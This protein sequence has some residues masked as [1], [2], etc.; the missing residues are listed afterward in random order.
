[1][2]PLPGWTINCSHD[3][4]NY[5][6]SNTNTK[7]NN[8]ELREWDEDSE[9]ESVSS[10][11]D[12]GGFKLPRN[13]KD[14]RVD[15]FLKRRREDP[16]SS[17]GGRGASAKK[18]ARRPVSEGSARASGGGGG[19]AHRSTSS[20]EE[21]AIGSDRER[22]ADF[23]KTVES[24]IRQ[25][26][27][28]RKK[29]SKDGA[30]EAATASITAAAVSNFGR[31]PV[32][33][34]AKLQQEVGRLTAALESL[35]EENRSLRAELAKMREQGAERGGARQQAQTAPAESQI[36]ALVRQE[37]A[38]FQARFS[39][40]EGRVLRPPLAASKPPAAQRASYAAAVA[41]TPPPR[42][43]PPSKP[44]V[45]A[46]NGPTRRAPAQ[47]KPKT[48]RAVQAQRPPVPPSAPA[49]SSAPVAKRPPKP[50]PSAAPT[51]SATESEWQVVG[52]KKKKRRAAKAAKKKAQKRRR[53][54]RAA[55]AQLRAPKTAA[56]VVT[57]Q[58]DAVKRGVSYRDVLA[59]AKEAVNL[60][61]LGI[62]SGLR[63][64]V[65]ATGARMLE[66]P[67]AASGPA[68]DAL[69]ERLRASISADDARVSRPQKCADLRIMGLDD[70]VT[71]EEV[72]AAVARTGGCSA[73]EVKAGTIRP[74]FRG[75]C[76]ITVSCPVTA[77][78]RIV[79]GRR[80]LV[81]WVSAQVKLLDPRPLR[82]FRCHVGHHVGVR[83]TSEVDRSALC[84][85][86]GQPGHKAV[87]CSAAPHCTA[88]AAAGKP[89]EHRAGSKSCAP[90]AKP[91]GR[92]KGGPSVA[93]TAT[94][95]AV[96]TTAAPAAAAAPN[97]AAAVAVATAAAAAPVLGPQEEE[98]VM[99][100]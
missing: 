70:S 86:C 99:E 53:R 22:R 52:E 29:A 96:A 55:A 74:D 94:T 45:A 15:A 34:L 69:A 38:A 62:A 72:V 82:C 88:C 27:L 42:R 12:A 4:G 61:E 80:L 9:S 21:S 35:V 79:D 14:H 63:L 81:G 17:S 95:S 91:K 68:A 18:V 92:G 100:C 44:P 59:Q 46:L 6:D 51:S 75:T 87:A 65:T 54:E 36:L 43:G 64:R 93:A 10:E 60:Q 30:I 83:C 78:K 97:A 2:R 67:G 57:L 77:A 49:P 24:A 48:A 19:A 39:V 73:D 71:A 84:F 16:G 5:M 26:A 90:P 13:K 98:D 23:E 58:P 76:T 37:M 47:P 50:T 41:A 56:V 32:S 89:A 3:R 1:M 7:N 11:G 31:A 33:E 25:V 28:K 66:V 85:R 8:E 20:E 40:L